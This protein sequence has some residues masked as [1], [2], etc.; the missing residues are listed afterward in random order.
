MGYKHPKLKMP[1]VMGHQPEILSNSFRN[2]MW[3]PCRQRFKKLMWAV[4]SIAHPAG[5]NTPYLC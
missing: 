5:K 3:Q 4:Q 1:A 2:S